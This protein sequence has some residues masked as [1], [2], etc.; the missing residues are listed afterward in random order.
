MF[1]FIP[2]LNACE[3][4]EHPW[5]IV[6]V[7]VWFNITQKERSCKFQGY[8]SKTPNSVMWRWFRILVIWT[9][10]MTEGQRAGKILGLLGKQ[11]TG[12]S[13]EYSQKG[14]RRWK[15]PRNEMIWYHLKDEK[16]KLHCNSKGKIQTKTVC[17][18]SQERCCS[19]WLILML[20]C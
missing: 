4:V 9:K 13:K 12:D 8:S 14:D 10:T 11:V 16:R 15:E 5:H 1:E 3:Q 2:G 17:C 18:F 7:S 6:D 20:C 19:K